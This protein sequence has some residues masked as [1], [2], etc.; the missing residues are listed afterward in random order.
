MHENGSLQAGWSIG[1][2]SMS[3]HS[4]PLAFG[5]E[6]WFNLPPLVKQSIE[7]SREVE[8][9]AKSTEGFA[10]LDWKHHEVIAKLKESLTVSQFEILQNWCSVLQDNNSRKNELVYYAGARIGIKFAKQCE[11]IV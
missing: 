11:S 3:R 6:D 2:N 7:A 4:L 5:K 8:A 1:S 9:D 10:A